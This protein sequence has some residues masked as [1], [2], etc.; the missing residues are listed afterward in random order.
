MI[1]K[2]RIKKRNKAIGLAVKLAGFIILF[3]LA[4]LP[5]L[6]VDKKNIDSKSEGSSNVNGLDLYF[7]PSIFLAK[8]S[9]EEIL[10]LNKQKILLDEQERLTKIREDK[11]SRILSLL[12]RNNSPVATRE[13]AVQI[14]N[15]AEQNDSD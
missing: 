2:T 5:F 7:D 4:L 12:S 15:L 6:I 11:L 13:Y 9:Y 14:L 3:S 1:Y 10:S 8:P